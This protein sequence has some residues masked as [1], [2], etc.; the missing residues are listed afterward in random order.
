M[1][2]QMI[3]DGFDHTVGPYILSFL[4]RWLR[5]YR[6]SMHII[7]SIR[8]IVPVLWIHVLLDSYSCIIKHVYIKDVRYVYVYALFASL[9]TVFFWSFP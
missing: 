9:L 2:I 7:P 6:G 1:I 8:M 5:P 3:T 4:F